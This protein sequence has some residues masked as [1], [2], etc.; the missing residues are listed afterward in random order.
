MH[1][2]LDKYGIKRTKNLSHLLL[3]ISDVAERGRVGCNSISDFIT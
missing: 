1:Y 3:K 2:I